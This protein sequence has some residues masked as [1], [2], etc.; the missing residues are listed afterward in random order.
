M[1]GYLSVH[2]GLQ[3]GTLAELLGLTRSDGEEIRKCYI[4]YLDVLISYF[5]TARAP[6]HPIKGGEDSSLGEYQWNIGE[7]GAHIA[8]GKGKEKLEHFGI[9]LEEEEDI[10]QQQTAYYGNSQITC[11]RCQD[12]VHY[13]FECPTKNEG[14][15]QI[16][17]S[18][19]KEPSTSKLSE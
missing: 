7:K 1:G 5:K 16:K 15:D 4:N 19:Y 12:F 13:A 8:V 2:F 10:K 14:K 18:S 11:Y 9:K 17:N 6:E 3:F